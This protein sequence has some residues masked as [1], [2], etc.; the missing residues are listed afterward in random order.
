MF[1]VGDSFVGGSRVGVLA[2]Q[3]FY[4]ENEFQ[5]IEDIKSTILLTLFFFLHGLWNH[6]T[7]MKGKCVTK[8]QHKYE[9]IIAII[10]AE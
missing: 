3:I 2:D 10:M 1:R 9:I 6:V 5:L 4:P 7:I 8:Y